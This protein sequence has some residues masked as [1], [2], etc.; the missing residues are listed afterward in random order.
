MSDHCPTYGPIF[1]AISNT[2]V[3]AARSAISPAGDVSRGALLFAALAALL[4]LVM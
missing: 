2:T 3:D 1:A 4:A